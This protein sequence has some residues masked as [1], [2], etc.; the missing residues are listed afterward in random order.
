VT[1][2]SWFGDVVRD[3]HSDDKPSLHRVVAVVAVAALTYAFLRHAGPL[4][5]DTMVGYATATSLSASPSLVGKFLGLRFGAA[6][7][8]ETS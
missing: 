2:H 6:K 8:E 7:K 4:T 1:R 3:E 5:W